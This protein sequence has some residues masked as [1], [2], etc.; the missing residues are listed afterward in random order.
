MP[1]NMLFHRSLRCLAGVL[2][3][4]A[5]LA[6]PLAALAAEEQPWPQ[7]RL[8]TWIVGFAPGGT[9]DVLARAVA[10]KLGEKTGQAVIVEN[11]PGGSGLVALEAASRAPADGYTVVTVSGPTLFKQKAPEIGK[12]LTAIAMLAQGPMVLV[13]TAADAP[14]DLSA[15]LQAAR[16][17]PG[18]WSYATSGAGSS[19]HLAGELLN[20]M[21]GTTMPHVPYR[22]GAA[23]VTDVIGGQVP[24]AMLGVTP[25]LAYVKAGKLKAYAVTTSHRSEV[26][27]S[28]PTMEEAGLKGYEASQWYVAAAPRGTAPERIAQ[29]NTWIEAIVGAPEF[30]P[31][32]DTGGSTAGKG[33]PEQTQEFVKG[34]TRRW[35]ALAEKARLGLE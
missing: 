35:K 24:L 19:Q 26:L 12:E 18:K 10:R 9:D 4:A 31:T 34:D 33:S 16:R 27:P 7:A 21:A 3:G 2:A 8:I 23:A 5:M 1:K 32:L 17:E 13:G 22:G 6:V 25:V 30:K 29:L 15:L 14:A 28:V 20:T 11:R